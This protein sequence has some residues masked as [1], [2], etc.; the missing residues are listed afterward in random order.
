[1]R[2]HHKDC[3]RCSWL[4]SSR[5]TKQTEHTKPNISLTCLFEMLQTNDQ[6][7]PAK[8]TKPNN[9]TIT[10]HSNGANQANRLRVC[11][12]CSK[13]NK[14][15]KPN[16]PNNLHQTTETNKTNKT[17]TIASGPLHCNVVSLT[18]L[19]LPSP[20]PQMRM[21][22]L[23]GGRAR[24]ATAAGSMFSNAP[25]TAAPLKPFSFPQ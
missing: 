15:T 9:A 19:H 10:G 14:P 17:R 12:K 23:S 18:K 7:E 13:P 25:R 2:K 20:W 16:S 22:F 8:Q 5:T 3:Q 1:M 4:P 24:R 11:S 6:T 21:R